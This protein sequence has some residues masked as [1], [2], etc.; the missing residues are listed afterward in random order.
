[1]CLYIWVA[2]PDRQERW[3]PMRNALADMCCLPEVMK[4][5]TNSAENVRENKQ[6]KHYAVC[7][8]KKGTGCTREMRFNY[9]M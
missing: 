4:M 6:Y 9:E 5:I 2:V 8:P 3:L 1:M 7:D